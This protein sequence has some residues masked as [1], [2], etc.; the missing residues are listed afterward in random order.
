MAKIGISARGE[1]VDFEVLAI[2]QALANA[3]Q[4]TSVDAR[5]QFIDSRENA[6]RQTTV[7]EYQPQ[8]MPEAMQL[9]LQAAEESL[10]ASETEV[11][12]ETTTKKKK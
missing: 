8:E 1:R 6:R 5:R 12:A 2:K 4:P 11:A 3:P 10:T 9:A 7:Q